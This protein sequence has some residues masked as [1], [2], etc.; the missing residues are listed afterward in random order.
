MA[1]GRMV[2]AMI[3]KSR[4]VTSF[5]LRNRLLWIGLITTAD[6]QGR[7]DA[8]PGLIR[9]V[10]FPFEDI[11]FDEIE[12]GLKVFEQE[13]LIML[14][15]TEGK[16]LY[17]IVNWWQNSHQGAMRWAWPSEY[18]APEGWADRLCYRQGNRV[19]K[20]NWEDTP[21]DAKEKDDTPPN[22][23]GPT[24]AP[25]RDDDDPTV[26]PA[27]NGNG[28]PREVKGKEFPRARAEKPP[29]DDTLSPEDAEFVGKN[30]PQP[31]P[32][33]E[34][35]EPQGWYGHHGG[36]N[37]ITVPVEAGG[38]H[39][40]AE[41]VVDYVCKH[42]GLR[43]SDDIP[44]KER[45]ASVRVVANVIDEWASGATLAQVRLAFQ[46]WQAK[47]YMKT[48][49]VHNKSF[50][51]DFGMALAGV[52]SGNTTVETLR[53]LTKD[54]DDQDTPKVYETIEEINAREHAERMKDPQY[55]AFYEQRQRKERAAREAAQ[56]AQA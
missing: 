26:S 10:V 1:R 23:D 19:I 12:D 4:K 49:D 52:M 29:P 35:F 41:T 18:P 42:N 13:G 47:T 34:P 14:Y 55:R 33:S 53:E 46:V 6:D 15:E 17:Q 3:W 51:R 27:P 56:Q 9:G 11:S 43:G 7:G 28:K 38:K 48:V 36:T 54:D 39:T 16:T 24:A 30:R 37:P 50:Q 20:E 25:P 44:Q 22:D 2:S 32:Q 8:H 5:S 21:D 31:P 45:V 40:A